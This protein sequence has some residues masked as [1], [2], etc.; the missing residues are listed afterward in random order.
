[1]MPSSPAAQL[2]TGSYFPLLL[3]HNCIASRLLLKALLIV[4]PFLA[5]EILLPV[6]LLT[7]SLFIDEP[8]SP[9]HLTPR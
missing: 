4:P 1:M 7:A 5:F 3:L 8:D 9:Y 6:Y 2:A